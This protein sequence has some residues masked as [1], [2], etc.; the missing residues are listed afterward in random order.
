[1]QPELRQ[2]ALVLHAR[3]ARRG[4]LVVHLSQA[5]RQ[6]G[7]RPGMSLSEAS[8]LRRQGARP[9][10]RFGVHDSRADRKALESLAA[11]CEAYSS[12]VGL[13]STAEP[14]CL[15][16]DV[17]HTA[18]GLGGE[19]AVADRLAAWFARSGYAVRVSV[20]DTIGTAWALAHF[21]PE[22]P[23]GP[24]CDVTIQ[25]TTIPLRAVRT[26]SPRIV[27]AGESEAAL[28]PLP[29]QALR[30]PDRVVA[31]LLQLGVERI[32]QLLALPRRGLNARFGEILLQRLDQALGYREETIVGHQ[33]IEPLQV[34][35]MLE[36]PVVDRQVIEQVLATL[37]D[38]LCR[39]LQ[40]QELGVLRLQ[41]YLS[42]LDHSGNYRRQ[43]QFQVG[44]YRPVTKSRLLMDLLRLQLEQQSLPWGVDSVLLEAELTAPMNERQRSL[45]FDVSPEAS[46][47]WTQLINRLSSRLGMDAV[48]GIRLLAEPQV[49]RSFRYV[50][51]TGQR[52]SSDAALRHHRQ[53]GPRPLHIEQPPRS[54]TVHAVP[55]EGALTLQSF[56]DQQVRH[57]IRRVW[58]PERIETGWWRGPTIRRDYYRVEDERGCRFWLF[59]RLQDNQWFL[60]GIFA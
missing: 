44:T 52:G 33:V 15:W 55:E 5:A 58:G 12:L 11:Q 34:E 56:T 28:R 7:V 40:Q 36:H 35:R 14:S 16:L 50:P 26:L 25:G 30:L 20:A 29:V 41:C 23:D 51:L 9:P 39:R 1:M 19:L 54:I 37:I 31:L 6:W 38:Q 24:W 53:T 21:G 49:E 42:G 60:Q 59:R 18:T 4:Q 32:E 27:A 17:T 45:L 2:S 22:E 47:Q 13:E 43:A 10:F 48:N 3:D 8:A 46:A 57:E